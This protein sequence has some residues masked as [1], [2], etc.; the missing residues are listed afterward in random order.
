MDRETVLAKI[1]I[2]MN[3]SQKTLNWFKEEGERKD[4]WFT[5]KDGKPFFYEFR[6]SWERI[7]IESTKPIQD[8]F[9]NKGLPEEKLPYV[10]IYKSHACSWEMEA[11]VIMCS[12]IVTVYQILKG[13]SELSSIANDLKELWKDI[14][15][16]FTRKATE[17]VDKLK[18]EAM[19]YKLSGLPSKPL[20]NIVCD[21]NTEPLSSLGS[22]LTEDKKYEKFS[23]DIS[24]LMQLYV[25]GLLGA[26][27][28]VEKILK[29]FHEK[30]DKPSSG[31]CFSE[32][33]VHQP[34]HRVLEKEDELSNKWIIQPIFFR[35][36][37]IAFIENEPSGCLQGNADIAK[38]V[39]PFIKMTEDVFTKSIYEYWL[40]KY[41]FN[42]KNESIK[43][44]FTEL[45]EQFIESLSCEK[46]FF[47][48][49]KNLTPKILTDKMG[50]I[51]KN[52]YTCQQLCTTIISSRFPS[53]Q[54]DNVQITS[55]LIPIASSQIYYGSLFVIIPHFKVDKEENLIKQ[56]ASDLIKCIKKHYV[57]ALA[58]MHEH[59]F[60]Y[61]FNIEADRKKRV[62]DKDG[63]IKPPY[64][65]LK[66]D[67]ESIEYG[68]FCISKNKVKHCFECKY[69]GWEESSDNTVEKYLHKLWQDRRTGRIDIK[70]SLFFKNRIY[71]DPKML[72]ALEGFLKPS[73]AKLKKEGDLL[74]SILVVATPGSG[75]EDIPKIIKLFSG[76]YSKG[77]IYKLNMASLKPDAVAPVTIV[78]AEIKWEGRHYKLE[79]ILR[80]IREQTLKEFKKFI[81]DSKDGLFEKVHE[82][83]KDLYTSI[84]HTND[85][86]RDHILLRKLLER[87]CKEKKYVESLIKKIE[88]KGFD[89][90]ILGTEEKRIVKELFRK[91][92]II[93]L[94]ELNSMSIE[95]QGV[96]LRLL[97]NAELTPLG[98]YEDKINEDD[99]DC[100]EFITD[101]LV[102]GIMNEDPE[103]ITREE[104]MKFLKD[105]ESY[106]GGLLGDFLYEYVLRV[107]RLR[108]DLRARIMRN[109]KF[110]IP[111]L[112]DR[113]ADIPG[114][115]YSLLK[116]AQ[117]DYF[118]NSDIRITIDAL[119]A[120]MRPELQWPENVRLLQ[121]LTKKV[122]EIVYED[123]ENK[124]SKRE[125]IPRNNGMDLIM[126]SGKHINQALK[127][128]EIGITAG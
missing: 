107:R 68:G 6:S 54:C 118:V 110:E 5:K 44:L 106:I 3:F 115:F 61:I 102:I 43:L 37:G 47:A 87:L 40:H 92:P 112:S 63:L 14:K 94:D 19:R 56:L 49:V 95:N 117:E 27:K 108:P 74:P 79:G 35:S 12:S 23:A 91:F 57:P 111:K 90:K 34:L 8:Y 96:L 123:Y 101:F 76:C 24:E 46:P 48:T 119:E 39:K 59:F 89:I 51:L 18:S 81:S 97:E 60:E 30:Y 62:I 55:L 65:L 2:K 26:N 126:I 93:V 52:N 82:Y 84:K 113:R 73:K 45:D 41:W 42:D 13:I 32:S 69:L 98:G 124:R 28:E 10:K 100:M 53:P 83:K 78:G 120:L 16:K 31:F 109:G 99:K 29:Y 75:K 72:D 103:E 4:K 77:K 86:E 20:D 70:E 128:M 121:S 80:Q 21:I 66:S 22:L 125:D 104:A 9:H 50:D 71:T 58:I 7:L 25:V 64:F 116:N 1:E 36:A 122:I 85:S 114:I 15:D 127:A 11:A 38:K 17:E 105:K 88:D 67:N 33:I